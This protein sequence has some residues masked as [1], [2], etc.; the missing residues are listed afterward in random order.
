MEKAPFSTQFTKFN[1]Q[2]LSSNPVSEIRVV[3]QPLYGADLVE[4]GFDET[5][6]YACM[7]DLKM[8]EV[9][10]RFAAIKRESVTEY[11]GAVMILANGRT[12]NQLLFSNGSFKSPLY[13]LDSNDIYT[14]LGAIDEPT[15]D[16]EARKKRHEQL[17]AP[18][19]IH[20]RDKD[21]MRFMI[22]RDQIEKS[23]L[24]K[25]EPRPMFLPILN[26][27]SA[28]E[29][30]FYLFDLP[31][32]PV[33]QALIEHFI[34]DRPEFKPHL[35]APQCY[36]PT[37]GYWVLGHFAS[38]SRASWPPYIGYAPG[39]KTRPNGPTQS[40]VQSILWEQDQPEHHIQGVMSSQI[41]PRLEAKIEELAVA[42][43]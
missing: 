34:Q 1:S 31:E 30:R 27:V 14:D 41:F 5:S 7:D 25:S 43:K 18:W 4:V 8:T 42:F 11:F 22:G 20:Y 40:A 10:I 3:E 33:H 17:G 36:N 2:F 23:Y 16:M 15:P 38:D 28:P 6:N 12:V 24:D 32:E 13:K 9:P 29:G 19:F 39:V 21:L 37:I 35:P 26:W